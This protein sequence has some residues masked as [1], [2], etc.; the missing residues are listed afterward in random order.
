MAV[1]VGD[2]LQLID[3]QTFLG[4]QLLNVYFYEVAES[5][6]DVTLEMIAQQFELDVIPLV[7]MMQS[8]VLM[9]TSILISNLTNGID[10]WEEPVNV[11]GYDDTN[12]PLASFYSFG[13]RLVRSTALTRHGSKRIGGVTEGMVDGNTL[14]SLYV[15]VVNDLGAQLAEPLVAEGTTADFVVNPVIVGRFPSTSST[16][17]ALDLSKINPVASAQFIRVTTQ[18]TRRAGRGS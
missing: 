5:D 16:P 7:K 4:Q 1:N 2:V 12:D 6:P 3:Q 17:G 11:A 9:H 15:T 10:I 14:A 18:T 8:E 13:F